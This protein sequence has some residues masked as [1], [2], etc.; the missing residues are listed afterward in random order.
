MAMENSI[1]S[2]HTGQNNKIYIYISTEIDEREKLEKKVNDAS[3]M[4]V[5]L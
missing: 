1:L 5:C 2:T 3:M 4:I